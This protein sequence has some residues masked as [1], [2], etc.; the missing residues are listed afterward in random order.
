[1][2]FWGEQVLQVNQP[3]ALSPIA[4]HPLREGQAAFCEG[5]QTA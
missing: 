5:H 3:L 2:A 4:F 1:M